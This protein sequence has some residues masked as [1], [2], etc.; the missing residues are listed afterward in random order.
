MREIG[1]VKPG[2]LVLLL[3]LEKLLPSESLG[4]GVT[5]RDFRGCEA[6]LN[7]G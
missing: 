5:E 1:G 4:T 3:G 6:L 2:V 7:R